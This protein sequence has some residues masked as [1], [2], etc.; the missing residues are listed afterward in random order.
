[1]KI[2]FFRY[3]VLTCLLT[4]FASKLP[5]QHTNGILDKHITINVHNVPLKEVLHKISTETSIGFSYSDELVSLPQRVTI[6]VVNKPLRA[7]LD[8]L[9]SGKSTTYRAVGNQI[10]FQPKKEVPR[11]I[12]FSGYVSNSKSS[13]R[14]IGCVVYDST[15]RV[16]IITN[17]FGYF[18]LTLSEGKH[19]ISFQQLGYT[20]SSM[21]INLSKDTYVTV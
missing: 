9:L 21:D 4:V 8:Q 2:R 16:G 5:A 7:V 17:A 13:E 11:K 3:V 6:N 1:M 15:S 18:N 10:V 20:S 12:T 19:T 14:L